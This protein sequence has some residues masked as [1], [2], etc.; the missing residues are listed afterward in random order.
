M[1]TEKD[2]ILNNTMYLMAIVLIAFAVSFFIYFSLNVIND[3]VFGIDFAPYHLAGKLLAKGDI[4][5]IFNYTETGGFMADKGEFLGYFHKYYFP[6]SKLVNRWI[7]FPAYLWIFYPFAVLNFS[8]ALFVWLALNIF[9]CAGSVFLLWSI[10]R[11]ACE[12]VINEP[13]RLALYLF[14]GLTFQPVF[15]NLMHG[16]V[17]GLMFFVFCMGYW[18]LRNENYFSAGLAFG[19]IIPLKF[20]PILFLFYFAYKRKWQIVFGIITM[21]LILTVIS[22]FTVG[23]SDFISYCRMVVMEIFKSGEA[24]FNNESLEG[25]LL[26]AFTYSNA[27]TWNNVHVPWGVSIVRICTV[28]SIL[29]AIIW[30]I[31]RPVLRGIDNIQ[32]E[33][34]DLPLIIVI[35]L[36]ISPVAWYHYYLWLLFSLFVAIEHLLSEKVF[37]KKYVI[38]LAISYA[39]VAVEGI[40]VIRPFAENTIQNILIFRIILSQSFYGAVILAVLIWKMRLNLSKG[41]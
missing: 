22:L 21:C 14:V 16:Q 39:L 33:D 29:S 34:M 27:N 1:S 30:S 17:T 13:L 12:S 18:F 35:M 41:K 23:V 2:K 11:K 8:N 19:F 31:T 4:H 38:W 36:L 9:L 3:A 28:L 32:I 15:S 37:K 6:Q 5:S 26:H 24:A 25:F 7:Y 10:R 40:S 20:Y